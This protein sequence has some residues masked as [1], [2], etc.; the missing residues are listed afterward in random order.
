MGKPKQR[1]R[2]GAKTRSGTPC[3]NWGM[4]NGRCRMHGGKAGRPITHGRYSVKHRASL[5]AKM[6]EFLDDPQP[7]NLKHEL[8]LQRA[9][10]QDFLDRLGDPNLISIK[11]RVH[12][13][14]M[15]DAISRLVERISR[16]LNQT[17]LT[18]IEVQLMLST[19][20]DLLLEFIDDPDRRLEFMDKFRSRFTGDHRAIRTAR[21]AISSEKPVE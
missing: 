10:L 13:F 4:E 2:C 17:A 7:G 18:Q 8:A 9:L 21:L 12:A 14:D 6:N 1:K 15:I 11:V 16:I 19:F 5:Q 3:Q 20:Q